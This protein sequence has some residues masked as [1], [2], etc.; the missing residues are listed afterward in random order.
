MQIKQHSKEWYDIR[1]KIL[2]ASDIAAVMELNP[3]KSRMQIFNEKVYNTNYEYRKDDVEIEHGNKFESIAKEHFPEIVEESGLLIHPEIPWLGASPDGY[4]PISGKLIEIKCPFS[5]DID[6]SYIPKYYWIQMQIQ[7]EVFNIDF[8]IFYQ[9]KFNPTSDKLEKSTNVTVKRDKNWFVKEC[10]PII[11]KFWNTVRYYKEPAH[12]RSKHT[13][14][15]VKFKGKKK[16]KRINL[17]KYDKLLSHNEMIDYSEWINISKTRNYAMR[18]PLLDWLDMYEGSGSGSGSGRNSFLHFIGFRR[19]QFF[20]EVKKILITD[21]P[22]DC[23]SV[24][25]DEREQI[26]VN[27]SLYEKTLNHMHNGDAI[28]FRGILMDHRR[29]I[30]GAPD[31]LIRADMIPK[32]FKTKLVN[33]TIE[34]YYPVQIRFGTLTLSAN[35][36]RLDSGGYNNAYKVQLA[37]LMSMIPNNLRADRIGLLMGPKYRFRS[38]CVN[39]YGSN[40]FDRA[41]VIDFDFFRDKLFLRIANQSI[42]WNK[43][44]PKKGH[45]FKIGSNVNMCPNMCNEFDSPWKN[46][47]KKISEEI[48]EITSVYML[49]PSDR[50]MFFDRGIKKWDGIPPEDVKNKH[51]AL[52]LK[53]NQ[54]K[55]NIIP[56][57]EELKEIVPHSSVPEFFVDFEG[58]TNSYGYFNGVEYENREMIFMIGLGYIKNNIWYYENFTAVNLDQKSEKHIVNSWLNRMKELDPTGESL[59]YHWSHAEITMTKH[60]FNRHNISINF[61]PKW[62]DLHGLFKKAPI[63]INGS[64]NFKLKSIVKAMSFQKLISTNYEDVDVKSGLDAMILVLSKGTQTDEIKEVKNY[65]EIDCKVLWEILEYL[66]NLMEKRS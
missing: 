12:T 28:I 30:Y 5:R 14:V 42:S 57:E 65:N 7:M 55:I 59:V 31:I 34:G 10:L 48:N 20:S 45:R 41:G 6:E 39:Y 62:F 26:P 35:G 24:H 29:K 18:D 36:T 43:A 38:K 58:I 66:R 2:T 54:E 49:G 60:A 56:S 21:F 52:I 25:T 8:C 22:D 13:R 9:C 50:Q 23:I 4:L 40:C 63:I 1:R 64:L 51:S 15:N 33:N 17:M 27:N 53:A 44:L 46:R 32:I 11:N 37:L 19:E 16:R 61:M 47:K 3:F